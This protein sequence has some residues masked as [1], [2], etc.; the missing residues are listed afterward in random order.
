MGRFF[1][2]TSPPGAPRSPSITVSSIS[3]SR[4]KQ[5]QR[6]ECLSTTV[7][8]EANVRRWV[9]SVTLSEI[10][11]YAARCERYM[12]FYRLGCS[13]HL[14]CYATR[15]Y[16]GHRMAPSDITVAQ[17]EQEYCEWKAKYLQKKNK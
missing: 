16:R 8:Q 9:S 4:A 1:L 7:G 5:L 11:K 12:R 10:R 13:V 15:R 3:L 17:I 2:L 14:A 6:N